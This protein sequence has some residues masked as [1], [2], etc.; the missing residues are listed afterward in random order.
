MNFKM[1][2]FNHERGLA[3]FLLEQDTNADPTDLAARAF[4]HFCVD[5]GGYNGFE[6]GVMLC[7]SFLD[8][9]MPSPPTGS[10]RAQALKDLFV[11]TKNPP[12]LESIKRWVESHYR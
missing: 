12:T 10:M 4:L 3:D 6:V 1:S 11:L 2:V 5:D 8:E 7:V 9:V